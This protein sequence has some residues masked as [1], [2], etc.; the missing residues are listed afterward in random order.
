MVV[1]GGWRFHISEVPLYAGPLGG[2]VPLF[3]YAYGHRVLLGAGRF[4]MSEVPL[5]APP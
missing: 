5:Y 1:L 3:A 4:L 2:G